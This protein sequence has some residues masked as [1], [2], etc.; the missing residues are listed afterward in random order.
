MDG[1]NH[2]LEGFELEEDPCIPSDDIYPLHTWHEK[3]W[4]PERMAEACEG[5]RAIYDSLATPPS[6]PHTHVAPPVEKSM[7]PPP[8]PAAHPPMLPPSTIAFLHG[9]SNRSAQARA[10]S[11]AGRMSVPEEAQGHVLDFLQCEAVDGV[12]PKDVP[13]NMLHDFPALASPPPPPLQLPPPL[14]APEQ[15]KRAAAKDAMPPPERRKSTRVRTPVS[16]P[17]QSPQDQAQS[18]RPN[19]SSSSSTPNALV[20]P[21]A[22]AAAVA[23]AASA[24]ASAHHASRYAYLSYPRSSLSLATGRRKR[25]IFPPHI[26]R[27]L[28]AAMCDRVVHPMDWKCRNHPRQTENVPPKVQA[29]VSQTGLTV[30]QIRHYMHNNCRKARKLMGM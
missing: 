29:L 17:L 12:L 19:A 5:L 9:T 23:S 7:P 30:R 20:L 16:Q 2:A 4:T 21:V 8:P 13:I 11:R 3:P 28:D 15:V 22:W 25:V 6:P 24:S 27:I 14:P 1:Y 18:N 10:S 26:K